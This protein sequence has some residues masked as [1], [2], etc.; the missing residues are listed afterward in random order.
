[1]T[2]QYDVLWSDT[3][4]NDLYTIVEYVYSD[5]PTNALNILDKIET[6]GNK[7]SRHSE[8]GRYVPELR[9]L[10]VYVY[11][12]LV[13]KPWRM[14]YRFDKVN[15]YILAVLDGRRNLQSLLIERLVR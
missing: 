13:V 5:S 9:E 11:R 10:D 8:R 3:A 2:N 6:Q 12:E 14:I 15:V 4:K 1:M 7:L